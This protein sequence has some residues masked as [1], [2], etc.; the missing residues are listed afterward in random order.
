M[1]GY[2]N[3]MQRVITGVGAGDLTPDYSSL[4][5]LAGSSADLLNEINQVL[6]ASQI[7]AATLSAMRTA[8]DTV[9]VGT[10]AGALN[11]VYAALTL[12][13]ASPEYI[14]QK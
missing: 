10:A 9:P 8:L 11:R 6:A 13:L 4:L 3:F 14:A 7:S 5:P 12:V 1:A 2:I